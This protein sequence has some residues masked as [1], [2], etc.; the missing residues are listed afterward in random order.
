M[1]RIVSAILAIYFLT[2]SYPVDANRDHNHRTP[3]ITYAAIGV[4]NGQTVI[5]INGKRLHH[6]GKRPRVILGG[7]IYLD[8]L[9]MD[10]KGKQLIVSGLPDNLLDGNHVLTLKNKWGKT[11][12]ILTVGIGAQGPPGSEGPPGPQGPKGDP[13]PPGPQGD[14]GVPGPQGIAGPQGPRGFQGFPGPQGDKGNPGPSGEKG[15]PGPEGPQGPP[16]GPNF[17]LKNGLGETIG[18]SIG[19][20]TSNLGDLTLSADMEVS[21]SLGTRNIVF[22]VDRFGEIKRP[23]KLGVFFYQN[24]ACSDPA[25]FAIG[26]E[27]PKS[28][29]FSPAILIETSSSSLIELY[30]DPN[31]P[32]PKKLDFLSVRGIDPLSTCNPVNATN[33]LAYPFSDFELIDSDLMA[34]NPPPYTLHRIP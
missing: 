29:A 28:P 25:F 24:T 13:G 16:G 31:N 21:T 19:I 10:S 2:I 11:D 27:V 14:E 20:A 15:D 8:V 18:S 9:K 30:V 33:T 23:I 4:L 5:D 6:R 3:I 26:N 22:G 1:H 34:T 17:I 7:M 12:F 32:A